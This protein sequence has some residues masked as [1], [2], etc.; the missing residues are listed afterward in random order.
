MTDIITSSTYQLIKLV[1]IYKDVLPLWTF[2]YV[3]FTIAG[4]FQVLGWVGGS[5][6]F[7]SLSLTP[8]IFV[9]CI[10]ALLEYLW[11]CVA[12][13]AGV[14]VLK[15]TEMFLVFIYHIVTI[16]TFIIIDT[17][18]LGKKFEPKYALAFLLIG[19]AVYI[20]FVW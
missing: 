13:N 6:I 16:V 14:E 8:R 9:F 11:S 2:P 10:L 15:Y 12:I 18:I 7:K 19:I 5:T 3:P 4:I 1:N 20:V 17:V